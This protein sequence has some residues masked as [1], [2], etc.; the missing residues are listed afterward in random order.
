MKNE[1]LDLTKKQEAF[2]QLIA[3]GSNKIDA[4]KNAGYAWEK[5]TT[6]SMHVG[7]NN[8]FV[9]PKVRLRIDQLKKELS[10]VCLWTRED[11]T[12]ALINVVKNPDKQSDV[13]TAVKELNLMHGYN[14]PIK[15]DA[16]VTNIPMEFSDFY[17]KQD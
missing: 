3:A 13:V 10:N 17:K 16:I 9:N 14:A 15:V 12:K 2:A 7:A 4:Y 1:I 5:C 8:V 6:S 11:S